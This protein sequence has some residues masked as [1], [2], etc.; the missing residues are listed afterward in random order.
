[1]TTKID[2]PALVVERPHTMPPRT[3]IA[4][5][6]HAI[7]SA[8]Y[9]ADAS[10]T[11]DEY[12][13]EDELRAVFGDDLDRDDFAHVRELI[14][15]GP[16]VETNY[17][18]GDPQW[19]LQ[20]EAPS[21]LDIAIRALADD[22]HALDVIDTEDACFE[23]LGTGAWPDG[24]G[25]E[26]GVV[27]DVRRFFGLPWDSENDEGER[28]DL[29]DAEVVA[30]LEDEG[31]DVDILRRRYA[32]L[33]EQHRQ[34]AERAAAQAAAEAEYNTRVAAWEAGLST[35]D[36]SRLKGAREVVE[37]LS[38]KARK[39]AKQRLRDLEKSLGRPEFER[40]K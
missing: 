1:M 4:R 12:D 23:W 8:A 9:E 6:E 21:E 27:A 16:V 29:D 26:A 40:A 32:W 10:V 39:R 20:T 18:H 36:A 31:F 24:H 3:W 30:E 37:G 15:K 7:I 34:Y 5:D 2:F 22:L 35:I 28:F 14:A 25:K 13:D 38:G 11:Y 19:F 33:D 17:G